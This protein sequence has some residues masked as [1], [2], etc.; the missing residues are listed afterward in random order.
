MYLTPGGKKRHAF[1][2]APF[3][4]GRRVCFGKTFAEA[5]M[6]ILAT[7]LTQHFNFEHVDEKYREKNTY[8]LAHFGMFG[9]G[10][11]MML[12]LTTHTGFQD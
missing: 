1:A 9:S 11:P 8:P 2:Y 10:N 12:E 5:T 7:Y 4:G 3:S 6:K